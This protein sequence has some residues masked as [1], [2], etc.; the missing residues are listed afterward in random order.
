M[1]FLLIKAAFEREKKKE[2][3]VCFEILSMSE[4]I[5]WK[6]R[7]TGNFIMSTMDE[8]MNWI[9]VLEENFNCLL[10]ANKST[11]NLLKPKL[12]QTENQ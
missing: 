6:E 8:M 12:C 3:R 10:D 2:K 5:V 1:I 11:Q 9:V 4:L 7:I